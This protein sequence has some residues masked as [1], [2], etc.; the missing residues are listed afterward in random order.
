MVLLSGCAWFT[1]ESEFSLDNQT[2]YEL[3]VTWVGRSDDLVRSLPDP[4]KPGESATITSGRLLNASAVTPALFFSRI[5]I[6]AKQ[7]GEWTPAYTRHPVKDDEWTPGDDE[8][9]VYTLTLTDADLT[10]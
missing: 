2:S 9:G 5:T 1:A 6:D 8:P 4:V 3:A 10:F 7:A